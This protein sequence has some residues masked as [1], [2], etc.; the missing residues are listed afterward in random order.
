MLNLIKY[1]LCKYCND[2]I[3]L[4]VNLNVI[5]YFYRLFNIKIFLF[6]IMNPI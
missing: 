2:N 4:N 5:D 3:F 6:F 1:F